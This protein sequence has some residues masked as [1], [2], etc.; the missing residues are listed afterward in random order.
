MQYAGEHPHK[1]IQTASNF[2]KQSKWFIITFERMGVD[3]KK[4]RALALFPIALAV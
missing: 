3:K 1:L 2:T 4:E